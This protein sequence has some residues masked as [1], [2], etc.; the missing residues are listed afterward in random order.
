MF[1][2]KPALSLIEYKK[3]STEIVRFGEVFLGFVFLC[4]ILRILSSQGFDLFD[5]MFNT[6]PTVHY[7]VYNEII[8]KNIQRK[9]KGKSYIFQP[10][11]G[12]ACFQLLDF[13]KFFVF[14]YEKCIFHKEYKLNFYITLRKCMDRRINKTRRNSSTMS[15]VVK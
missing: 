15:E 14:I 8:F 9:T 5:N 2:Q 10:R 4:V 7:E 6:F 13:Y 1:E 12:G 3:S 11:N